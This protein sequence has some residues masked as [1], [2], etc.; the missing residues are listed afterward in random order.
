MF[1]YIHKHSYFTWHIHSLPDVNFYYLTLLYLTLLYLTLPYSTLLY[2]TLPYLTLL[3]WHEHYSTWHKH[4][5]FTWCKHPL[6]YCTWRMHSVPDVY[7][8]HLTW[9]YFIGREPVVYLFHSTATHC[10][11]LQHTAT[12]CTLLDVTLSDVN[13]TLPD[14][15]ILTLPDVNILYFI[16]RDVNITLRDVNITLLYVT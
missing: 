6:L 5:Y 7:S 13:F 4:S 14:T 1:I 2:L 11:T 3:Y 9:R 10:N 8:F 16:L 12:H 15:N